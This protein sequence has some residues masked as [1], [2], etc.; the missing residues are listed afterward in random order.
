MELFKQTNF[1]FLRWKWHFIGA[2]LVLSVAGLASLALHG[3]PKL[4][5]EFKGGMEMT[6]KFA[7]EPP[8]EKVRSALTSALSSAPTV[9]SF[10][11]G[12][13]EI[14]IG[15]EG[16]PDAVL[17]KNRQLVLDTL[18]KTFG[19][20]GNGKLDL[21]NATT[22]QLTA[23]LSE[24]L[25][26]AGVQLSDVQ[27]KQLVVAILAARDNSG[28]VITNF[29][30]L[31]GTSGLTPQVLTVLNQE[32][33]L[34][35]YNAARDIQIVG[36]K[37]G[38][39]LRRQAIN[40][41]L[42]ALG[43]MLVY[44]WFRFEWIYGVGAVIACLHDTIITIGLFSLFG[45]EI[46]LTVIAALLTLVGYSMNDTIVIFDRIRENN[47]LNNKEKLADLINRSVNQTLSRTVMTSGL[48]F[49]A[50]IALFLFGGPVLHGFAFALVVGILI[51]TYSSVFVASPIVLFWHDYADA[52][53]KT[54]P[55]PP[56][57]PKLVEEVR[58]GKQMRKAR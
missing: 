49:L 6:V 39:E 41:T 12:K 55:A 32:C 30:Q 19:Q 31:R 57:A 56:V 48:T 4:G 38:D 40:A 34:S 45:K 54:A 9:Q 17:A 16:G 26:R 13:N 1:D 42:L 51:G 8:V 27:V 44:I 20:P 25:Q 21:N 53:K 58:S 14:V 36:P 37:V 3:G 43:G 33:Y 29:D 10:E 47:R 24:P 2:S 28:G 5:I 52:R 35:P 7:S 46:T 11:D 22:D 23:R 18:A 15:T 50:V